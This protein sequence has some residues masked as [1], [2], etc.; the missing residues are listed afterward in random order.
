MSAARGVSTSTYVSAGNTAADAAIGAIRAARRNSPNMGEIVM[1][2]QKQ[3]AQTKATALKAEAD[4]HNAGIRKE[5]AV[6]KARVQ[7][8][9]DKSLAKSKATVRK[10]GKIAAAG[11]L[12]GD[13]IT[14]GK[15]AKAR[16]AIDEKYHQLYKDFFEKGNQL[17]EKEEA[18][19]AQ[20]QIEK[21]LS[22]IPSAK[23]ETPIPSTPDPVKSE[24]PIPSTPDPVSSVQNSSANSSVQLATLPAT[25]IN[26]KALKEAISWAEGTWNSDTNSINY[27]TQFGGGQFDGS[28]GHPSQV[29][30]RPGVSSS[31]A[32]GFQF[33]PTTWKE[34]NQG[35]NV[36]MTPSNQD[37]A[38]DFLI[39]RRGVDLS[40]PLEGQ[41]GKLSGEWASIP[42]HTG[43][44]YYNMDGKPYATAGGIAQPS[45]SRE[46]FL[47]FYRDR[48]KAQEKLKS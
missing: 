1:E 2:G 45:K 34:A 4:I 26:L 23:P 9:L 44:S 22:P 24:T 40:K 25:G 35:K 29:I 18:S 36:P 39:T 11:V 13:G 21:G 38:A 27:N 12:I 28:K 47:K 6:R 7:A 48:I 30:Q 46:E 19:D 16:A 31:A 33:M 41:I 37:A 8:D 42:T 10:A 15:E 43:T 17:D 32:G 3:R 14:E 20:R 5:A